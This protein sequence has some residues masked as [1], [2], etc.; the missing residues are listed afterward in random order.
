[1]HG[2]PT[3]LRTLLSTIPVFILLLGALAFDLAGRM[4]ARMMEAGQGL[5]DGYALLRT[6]PPKPECDPASFKVPEAPAK[7]SEAGGDDL[8]DGLDDQGGGGKDAISPEAILSAKRKC[9]ELHQV[10]EATLSR[11]TP[12]LRRFDAVH[13]GL[14]IVVVWGNGLVKGLM[15]CLLLF[16]S[17][18]AS[19]IGG[20]IGLR[21]TSSVMD[22]RVSEG[23]QAL[24]TG[25]LFF[26]VFSQWRI[27]QSAGAMQSGSVLFYVWMAGFGMMC[28]VHLKN[29]FRPREG[30]KPGGSFG[31]ATLA[32]PL[33][34]FMTLVAGA[35]FLIVEAHAPGLAIYTQQMAEHPLLYIPVGLYVWIGMLLKQTSIGPLGF[36]VVR[37]WRLPPE[38]LAFVVVAFAAWP[39]AYSGA[40][41]IFVM[42]VGGLIYAELRRAGARRQL[43]LAATAMS[44]SLG[45]VLRPCLLV[46]IVASLNKEVTT[47]ELYGW[48]MW[49]YLGTATLFL[50]AALVVRRINAG[51]GHSY[52]IAPF[53]EG[54]T[55]MLENLRPLGGYVLLAALVLAFYYFG[56]GTKVDEHTAPTVLP[57]L[58]LVLLGYDRLRAR[59]AAASRAPEVRFTGAALEAT[60]E[61][62]GHIGALLIMM[63][64]S[65]AV[66]GI[67]ERSEVMHLV[68]ETFGSPFAAMTLLV[69]ILVIVGMTMDP[70]GAVILVS[71]SFAQVAYRNG[72]HPAHFWM[73]VLTAFE[74]GY[75]TPP[76]ALNQLLARQV[77]GEEEWLAA[78][79][80][81][82]KSWF[83]RNES[84]IIPCA[85]MGVALLVVAFVPLAFY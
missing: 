11:V 62:S 19:A 61:T 14:E 8:L 26:S 76:V 53:G 70:Y 45:V 6:E 40:S 79:N 82:G 83:A 52:G 58:M 31:H 36:D 25:L 80:E 51:A 29:L 49:V 10:Y 72:I 47:D 12:G 32:V 44:G 39:T 23:A 56:L 63:A 7:A 38:L 75:L 73:T 27:D 57:V 43:A 28:L 64:C 84:V 65:V 18:T 81:E 24:A 37:P 3:R 46:V 71:A 77:V 54:F 1:M 30:L 35:Y 60:R 15:I 17:I 22:N 85:I 2:P 34:A 67:V 48:G 69:A 9:E 59:R 16:G 41:G 20:H 74:L 66:G 55:G 5:W 13:D 21:T 33:Y 68:P 50:I 4:N 42:A 78:R